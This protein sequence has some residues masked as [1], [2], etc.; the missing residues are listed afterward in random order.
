MQ[1]AAARRAG[2]R[3]LVVA[4]VECE[5][6]DP[7]DVRAY[8][9]VPG[10]AGAQE[11]DFFRLPFP[12]DVRIVGGKLDLAGFPTP[13][14]DLLGYDP[15][16]RY[17]DAIVSSESAWGTYPT[18][19]FRFSGPID[20]QSLRG[21]T[22][23]YPVNWVD[24]TPGAPENGQPQG[25]YW[26]ASGGRTKY[27]CDHWVGVRA[28]AGAPLTPGHTYA[29]WITT[30]AVSSSGAKIQRSENFVALLGSAVPSDPALAAAHAR[31]APFRTFLADNNVPPDT[32]LNATV[33]TT[34]DVRTTMADLA[35]AVEAGPVPVASG[36]VKCGSGASSPCPQAEG[37]R[38]CGSGS[39]A[40]DE[41]HALVSLPIFQQ[42]TAPYLAPA[43]GG[44]VG[45]SPVRQEDVC[46]ALTVPKTAMPASGWPLVVFAH[47]TGGSFRSHVSDDVAGALS[48]AQ[49][50][51]GSVGFAV[52]G[53]DQVQRGP[54]R[55]SSTQSPDTLFYNFANPAAARGNPLQGAVDQV[56]LARFAASLDVTVG[57]DAIQVDPAALVFFGHSQGAGHGSVALPYTDVFTAAVLSGNGAGLTEALLDK[58]QPVN[59][60]AAVPWV[61]ADPDGTG[62][63]NG[64][65]MNPVLGLLQQWS[66]RGDPLNFARAIARAPIGTHAPKHVFQTYGLDDHF[67]PPSTLASFALAG[68]LELVS[69]HSSVVT[70]D[71]IGTLTP[72]AAPLSGNVTIGGQALTLGVRQ[73]AAPA[74]TDGHFV[75]FAAP[76]ARNDVARFLGMAAL[77][78]VPAIGE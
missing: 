76:D 40:F 53:I 1:P 18:V 65:A 11:G 34:A 12:N 45:D 36:W 70:P 38:A 23:N 2:V 33:I 14:S 43:D 50:P 15:V 51:I 62:G 31:F 56:A 64:G 75:A 9:E 47:G 39:A 10:A 66:D 6:P 16:Q 20:Y 35:A 78:Q 55:G 59:I 17:I 74:G 42:G 26:Y 61:L 68:G 54:R 13:G 77:G 57:A 29:V 72:K 27:V 7:T 28:P 3:R 58:T 25:L 48:A 41:Y 30:D 67:S 8:F 19:L 32:I 5:A 69:A 60:A 71:E 37:D 24:I 73:Y 4:G 44:D 46:L 22:G 21:S 52:L 63:L 49:T